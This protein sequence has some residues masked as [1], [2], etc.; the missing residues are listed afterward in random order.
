MGMQKDHFLQIR[1]AFEKAQKGHQNLAKLVAGLKHTYNQLQDKD[2]NTFHE[3]FINLLK[4]LMTIYKREPAVERVIEFVA[5]FATA[6]EEPGDEEIDEENSFISFL[7]RFLLKSHSACSHSVRFRA[8]QLINKLLGSMSENAQIDDELY[9]RIYE[10]MLV[11]LKDKFPNVRIQAVFAV[12]RLQDPTDENC[13]VIDAYLH[14]IECDTNPEV[15]RAVLSCIGPSA[16]TLTKIIGRTMDIKENVRRLAYEV[17]AEKIHIKA[18]SIAQ[19]VKLLTQGL[20]DRSDAVKE[21][22]QKKLLP[23]WLRTMEGNILDLLH[24]LDVENC[25]TVA[26]SALNALFAQTPLED[27]VEKCQSLNHGKVISAES[28]T[29][30]NALYWRCL[31][32]YMKSMGDEREEALEKLLPEAAI[33]AAYLLSYLKNLP[34]LNESQRADFVQIEEVMKKEFI[35]Q[36]LIILVG[37]LD[38]SEEGGRKCLLSVLQEILILPNT[39]SSLIALLMV[40]LLSIQKDD[41]RRIRL[42]AEIISDVREP[43]VHTEALEN[44]DRQR[45]KQV[46]LANIK[47]QLVEAKQAL[48]DSITRQDFIQASVLKQKIEELENCKIEMIKAIEQPECKE[49]YIEKDDPETMLKCLIMCYE[50]LKQ[51]AITKGIGPTLNGIAEALILPS[52]ANVNPAVRNMAVLCL[53]S[54]A[55]HNKD[56]AIQHLPLLLQIAQLD[57]IN[58]K[59]SA[60]RAVF[61]ILQVFGIEAFKSNP[62]KSHEMQNEEIGSEIEKSKPDECGESTVETDTVNSIL[63]LL[64]G[65]LDNEVIDLRTVA[66]EGFAKLFFS[67]R[68][69]SPK[70]LSRLILLWYN[71]VTEEDTCLRHCLGVFFPLYAFMNRKNQ[72]CFQEAFLPTLRTLFYAPASSPLAE[73]NQHNVAEL[74]VDLT[75]A[76]AVNVQNKQIPDYQVFSVHDNLAVKICNEILK[77]P[78]SPDIRILV[79]TLGLLDLSTEAS[80]CTEQLCVLLDNIKELKNKVNQRIIE[81]IMLHLRGGSGDN[82]ENKNNTTTEITNENDKDED[83]SQIT[84]SVKISK[85]PNNET[86]NGKGGK[87]MTKS[88]KKEQ[89]KCL[90]TAK[91]V[92]RSR[93]TRRAVQSSDES[94]SQ[95]FASSAPS[96]PTRPSRRAKTAALAKTKMNLSRLLNKGED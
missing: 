40:Q 6:F 26:E 14:L 94:D 83:L 19:R 41:D 76:N 67:G 71:P 18:F 16:K 50:L 79:K 80:P 86:I 31:C 49:V 53:G 58:V 36:Q 10:A 21:V 13:P 32:K 25:V 15:R 29:C 77:D 24:R 9:D 57:M 3:E 66:A 42:V 65:Y 63:T 62:S 12:S 69:S 60:L 91:S 59:I 37:C 78:D 1:Q 20:A 38:T 61:D 35:S 64:L 11:R 90:S 81:K 75:R 82:E 55:L 96:V 27:L 73:V 92:T 17:L 54:S 28:L 34:I 43:I 2:K 89:G 84:G 8:C 93:R 87:E 70:I 47:V 46:E 23:A 4:Y 95:D 88:S 56:F 33:Y 51:M 5:R 52:I 22:V 72:E 44:A 7:F 45:K 39:P 68:L 85:Q 48:E 74:F 30:E